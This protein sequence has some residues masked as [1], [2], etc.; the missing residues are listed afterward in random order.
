MIH[1]PNNNISK[2]NFCNKDLNEFP[3]E[4]FKLKNLKKLNLS[5]NNIKKIPKEIEKLR[6]LEVLDVSNNKISTLYSKICSLKKLKVLNLNNNHIKNIPKQIGELKNIEILQIANNEVSYLPNSFRDLIN[7]RQLNISKNNFEK[8]PR[9]ILQNE[10]ITH[11]WMNDLRLASFPAKDIV[12]ELKHLK[13]IY[14]F[15]HFRSE[16]NIDYIYKKLSLYKGNSNNLL[17][18]LSLKKTNLTTP[19]KT[20][21]NNNSINRSKIFISYSHKDSEWLKKIQ[22][23]LKVLLHN[24]KD[25]EV[26]D[27]TKIKAGDNWKLEIEK[28]LQDSGIAILIISTDFLASDFIRSDELPTILRNAK[29]NGTRI[30]PVIVRPCMFTKDK[31][32][33]EFQSVNAP[34]K[35]LSTLKDSQQEIELVQL[36]ENVSDLIDVI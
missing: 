2:L 34:E 21:T 13:A 12:E 9:I 25:F 32:L 27:D 8:F 15:G 20:N 6:N 4:I 18:N 22:T 30:L 17:Q 29:E 19:D 23:H 10:N 1:I 31:N 26:W 24:D 11:L 7:L 3:T 16:D 36:A 14:C 35:A 33:A 5:G 28:A